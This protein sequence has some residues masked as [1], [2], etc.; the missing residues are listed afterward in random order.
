[1][2]DRD[3]MPEVEFT[4]EE[5]TY[6]QEHMNSER[7][8]WF[9]YYEDLVEYGRTEEAEKA[10]KQY[11]LCRSIRD[12]VYHMNGRDTLAPGNHEQRWWDQQHDY[13]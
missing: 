8:G 5:L 11:E 7:A 3:H 1:M 13:K 4:R 10:H 12:K 2:M 6:L 9:N